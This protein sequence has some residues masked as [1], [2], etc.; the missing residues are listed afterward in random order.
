MTKTKSLEQLAAAHYRLAVCRAKKRGQLIPD[1]ETHIEAYLTKHQEREER[2]PVDARGANDT[3]PASLP[4]PACQSGFVGQDGVSL[5]ETQKGETLI[6]TLASGGTLAEM[7]PAP[8][9]ASPAHPHAATETRHRLPNGRFPSRRPLCAPATAEQFKHALAMMSEGATMSAIRRETGAD[10]Q[11]LN[12]R[13]LSDH[14]H[15]WCAI[16]QAWKENRALALID[17]A[18]EIAMQ[19]SPAEVSEVKGPTGTT[20]TE[21][22]KTDPGML[23]AAL[24]GLL[25]GIHGRAAGRQAPQINVQGNAAI[26]GGPPPPG[27]LDDFDRHSEL[28][29]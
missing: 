15:D 19:E 2:P 1:R 7:Q 29:S 14:P 18:Q 4:R 11:G 17:R 16:A 6:E 27:S 24:A 3:E 20:T 9:V 28:N 5:T 13:G 23:T 26:F 21:R 12:E 10:W 8:L 25:P 22:R